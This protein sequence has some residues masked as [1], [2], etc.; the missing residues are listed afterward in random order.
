MKCASFFGFRYYGWFV[1]CNITDPSVPF[2]S[3]L[4][5]FSYPFFGVVINLLLGNYFWF[6]LSYFTIVHFSCCF[7][8]QML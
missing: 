4:M 2:I 6:Y 8:T 7:V 3:V 5:S 1:G